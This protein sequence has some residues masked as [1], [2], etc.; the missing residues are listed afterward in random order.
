[1]IA[2]D[3]TEVSITMLR[4]VDRYLRGISYRV[5]HEIAMAFI[6]CGWARREHYVGH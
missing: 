3:P 2:W 6:S 1:M 5:N 4:S